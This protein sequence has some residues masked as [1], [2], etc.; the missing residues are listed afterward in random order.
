MNKSQIAKA[1]PLYSYWRSD[2]SDI[3]EAKRLL[4]GNAGSISVYLFEKEPYKWEC[5]FQ[6]IVSELVYGNLDS[7]R[8]IK[9]LLST[10]NKAEQERLI[11]Y[12]S[13]YKEFDDS[14]IN[15]IKDQ[16]NIKYS[17]KNIFRAFRILLVIFTNTYCIELKRKK[18]HVYEKTGYFFYKISFIAKGLPNFLQ[19]FR[20]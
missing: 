20:K 3:E 18:N 9:V 2:Q 16:N 12:L 10:L 14:I 1:S 4:K 19:T 8:G 7:I 13:G 15:Q 11:K 17:K 5:L 6:S